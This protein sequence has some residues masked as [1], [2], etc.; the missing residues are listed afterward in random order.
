[1]RRAAIRVGLGLAAAAVVLPWLSVAWQLAN[2]RPVAASQVAPTGIVWA[3]RVFATKAEFAQWLRD[4]GATYAEWAVLHAVGQT[5]YL[6]LGGPAA[7][8]TARTALPATDAGAASGPSTFAPVTGAA[9]AAL[10]ARSVIVTLSL[11]L[12]G[13]LLFAVAFSPAWMPRPRLLTGRDRLSIEARLLLAG[14]GIALLVGV[15]VTTAFG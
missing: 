3:D 2:P 13:T 8:A 9:R 14:T 7:T 6:S 10:D 5:P 1:M 15:A 12:A 4:R 11:L